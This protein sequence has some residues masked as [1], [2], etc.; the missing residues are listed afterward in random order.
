MFPKKLLVES[1]GDLL[2]DEIV[3]RKKM[4]FSFPWDVWLKSAL[5]PLCDEKIKNLARRDIVNGKVLLNPWERYLHND[6]TVRWL[7]MWLCTVL[8][9]WME[10]N[11]I[12]S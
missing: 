12:E 6:K 9:C 10:E 3:H 8:E 4:G 5:R 11:Q 2:P 7:D 1:L